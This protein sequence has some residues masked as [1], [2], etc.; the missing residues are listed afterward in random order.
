MILWIISDSHFL[1]SLKQTLASW[2]IL[3]LKWTLPIFAH[4]YTGDAFACQTLL[5]RI[6]H[7]EK[8]LA[9]CSRREIYCCSQQTLSPRIKLGEAKTP[10]RNYCNQ[11]MISPWHIIK[12]KRQKHREHLLMLRVSVCVFI[13]VFSW[14]VAVSSVN[15]ISK[16]WRVIRLGRWAA[17]EKI[18]PI[19]KKRSKCCSYLHIKSSI[20]QG[21]CH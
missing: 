14:S 17:L 20:N 16:A 1:L 10:P 13:Y 6:Y 7:P 8:R 19:E 5:L 15:I 11:S 9:L 2:T 4:E 21:K 3:Q 18:G 12:L